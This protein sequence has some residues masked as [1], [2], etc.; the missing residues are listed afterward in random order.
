MACCAKRKLESNMRNPRLYQ[1]LS[2][3]S[4]LLCADRAWA[5]CG[6]PGPE[7][8]ILYTGRNR[9]R[10]CAVRGIGKYPSASDFGLPNNS[11]SAIDVGSGVRA[12][13]YE[14][15]ILA[16]SRPISRAASTMIR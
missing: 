12:V 6:L 15:T 14:L 11:I 9:G 10:A 16:G 5:D 8:V 4:L 1:Y 7:E 3:I 13:L 2:L